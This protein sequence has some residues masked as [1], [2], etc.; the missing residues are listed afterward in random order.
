[1]APG[2]A[3]VLPPPRTP[4]AVVKPRDWA[5]ERLRA[6]GATQRDLAA[7]WKAPPASVSRWLDGTLL[8]DLSLSRA[9]LFCEMTGMPLTEFAHRM[10]GYTPATEQ[11]GTA[12]LPPIPTTTVEPGPIEGSWR[13]L[14]HILV[15]P[16]A[17]ARILQALKDPQG[18]K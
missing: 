14:L 15:D 18:G 5:K 12:T 10:T 7:L 2:A 9:V 17:V 11:R 3:I 8:T 1:M 6:C 16:A 4:P 13:L